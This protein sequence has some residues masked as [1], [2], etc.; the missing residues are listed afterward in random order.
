MSVGVV[1]IGAPPTRLWRTW[2][3]LI[4]LLALATPVLA[5][6]S[7]VVR[8]PAGQVQGTQEGDVQIFRGIPYARPPV[9]ALR[10]RPPADLPRRDGVRDAT[11]FGAACPQPSS[12]FYDLPAVSED[13]LF[14]NVWKPEDAEGAPVLLWI[15]GGSLVSGTGSDPAQDG[16]ALAARGV[17]VVSINYRLGALGWLAHPGLS[18]ESDIGVSGNY[19]LMDQVQALHWVHRNIRAFG[20]D[21]DQVT[22]GGQSAG[23]LSVFLL[24]ADPEAR[25][26]FQRAIVQSGYMIAMP[27]LRNGGLQDW[28]DAETIGLSLADQ[29]GVPDVAALRAMSAEAIVQGVTR[30]RYFP[31][32]TVDGHLLPRQLVDVFDRGEQAPVPMLAGYNEGEIRSL[33]ILLPPAPADGAAY[34]RE[35]RARYGDLAGD[36]LH[37]YPA[38]SVSESMKSATRDA[39]YG[40]AA[41]RAVASQTAVGQPS[42]LYYFD[43]GYP[44]ADDRGFHAF[45]GSEVPY[46][47]GTKSSLPTWWPAIPDTDGERR[48]ANAMLTYWARFIGDGVPT[49][50]G[51][52]AWRPYDQARSFMVFRDAPQLGSMPNN[53]FD[54]H[55]DVVC[56]RRRQGSTAWHWNVGVIAPAL[57]PQNPDCD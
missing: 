26:L 20:G 42:F 52:A 35:I 53:A 14:L 30:T 13:C 44:A 7:P 23:G 12:P 45:H 33:P 16:A 9:G 31:L 6:E 15:H 43:H 32:A 54:L 5:T 28:P 48:L 51:E 34:E 2:P 40:W 39:M 19:G 47:F 17:V 27:E 38:G 41:E 55:E 8:A 10:W 21:P 56:R 24:M 49:A 11:R 1:P 29:L 4:L 46:V 50:P 18:A 22:I 3:I 37:Q 36:Y 25:G 57:P